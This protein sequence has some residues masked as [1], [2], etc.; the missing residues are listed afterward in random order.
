VETEIDDVGAFDPSS[1]PH[2][3]HHLK[4]MT[5]MDLCALGLPQLVGSMTKM[6]TMT[7]KKMAGMRKTY[8]SSYLCHP[9]HFLQMSVT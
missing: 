2:G 6:M 1:C 7:A 4:T 9:C 5:K 3:D 8:A